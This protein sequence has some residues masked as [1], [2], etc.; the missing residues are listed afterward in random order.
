M[1][2]SKDLSK[3]SLSKRAFHYENRIGEE[4]VSHY[5]QN[6]KQL[7]RSVQRMEHLKE[8]QTAYLL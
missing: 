1:G 6:M 2:M 7:K 3:K 5:F 4:S 8:P